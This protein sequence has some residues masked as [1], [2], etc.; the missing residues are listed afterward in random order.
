LEEKNEVDFFFVSS[1]KL[2]AAAP[3]PLLRSYA[4]LLLELLWPQ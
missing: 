1:A 3:I 2:R 4:Q